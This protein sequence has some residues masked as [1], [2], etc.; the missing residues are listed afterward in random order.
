MTNNGVWDGLNEAVKDCVASMA[1]VPVAELVV[2]ERWSEPHN[3]V[4]VFRL[5]DG[6]LVLVGHLTL[7]ELVPRKDPLVEAF[8]VIAEA[9]H[10]ARRR[11]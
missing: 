6:R 4:E 8:T 9:L 10:E 7:R 3:D 2:V 5:D 1:G 11:G